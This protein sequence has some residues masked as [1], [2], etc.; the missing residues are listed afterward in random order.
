MQAQTK[1]PHDFQHRTE[2]RIAVRRQRPI[3]AF[4]SDTRL[5]CKLAHAFGAGDI[6]ESFSDNPMV[7]VF[8]GSL[9][10]SGNV[11]RTL[12]QGGIVISSCPDF[13]P[14]HVTL[15][16][17]AGQ[18]QGSLHVAIL[19]PL[20][21][22]SQEDDDVIPL[23]L[24]VHAISRTVVDAKF[25]APATDRFHVASEAERQ[26]IQA[27]LNT[28]TRLSVAQATKPFGKDLWRSS[29]NRP[30]YLIR[31]SRASDVRLQRLE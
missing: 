30:L 9:K 29:A 20:V 1:G 10:I 13:L 16:K 7:A 19:S 14:S 11:T 18:C 3:K 5:S 28:G 12:E 21:A 4:S 31:Y 23:P 8:Q 22:S 25:T 6:A 2:F 24:E 17:V 27:H 15:R 26:S